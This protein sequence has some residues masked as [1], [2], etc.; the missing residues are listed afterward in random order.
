MVNKHVLVIDGDY[1]AFSAM[2]AAEVEFCWHDNV[3]TLECDHEKAFGIFSNTVE[4]I[5]ERR[6]AWN[7]SPVVLAFTDKVNWR[8]SILESY[9]AN[10]KA[11]RKP[12]G[13]DKFIERI[14]ASDEWVS[15]CHA[16]LEGD[17]IM[18][19]VGTNPSLVNA[20]FVTLVSCDKDFKTIPCEF[21]WLTTGEILNHDVETANYYHMYQ[22]IMGDLTDGYSGIKGIGAGG[23]EEF[24]ADPFYYVLDQK[25]FKSGPRKGETVEVY[26]KTTNE[27]EG[28]NLTL[29]EQMETLA[30]KQGMTKGELLVQA[31]VA[32][33][34]HDRH[35]DWE[36]GDITLWSP[37][38]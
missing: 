33:I 17:D 3:W 15:L 6:K 2:A 18:G 10:R 9:K 31:Q 16:N 21:Y 20:N 35:Y 37:N 25:T 27:A 19:I 32:C 4:T 8:K 13:Y 11:V 23:A 38:H 5:R 7:K 28:T 34:L 36:S 14:K 22:T 30:E 24:L 26:R 1:L 12:L 29:W